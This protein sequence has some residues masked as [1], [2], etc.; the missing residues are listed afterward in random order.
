MRIPL[1]AG[2]CVDSH[3]TI[4]YPDFII[5]PEICAENCF[6]TDGI[7][8]IMSGTLPEFCPPSEKLLYKYSF[9]QLQFYSLARLLL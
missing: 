9:L 4:D 5:Q 2:T 1:D 3:G 7:I 8:S 6:G